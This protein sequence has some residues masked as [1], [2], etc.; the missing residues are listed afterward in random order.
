VAKVATGTVKSF[1]LAKHYGFIQPDSGTKDVFFHISQVKK[2]DLSS[3]R[4]GQKVSFEIVDSAGKKIAENLHV[5]TLKSADENVISCPKLETGEQRSAM[6]RKLITREALQAV[7]AKAV[8][9]SSPQCEHFI[10]IFVQTIVP[11]SRGDV[12]WALQ[13][14]KYGTAERTQCDAAISDIVNL[15]QLEFVIFDDSK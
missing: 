5:G 1:N 9:E 4:K 2:S 6:K 15:L 8:R 3:L 13:G 11:K 7:I 14:V 12:N 10:G